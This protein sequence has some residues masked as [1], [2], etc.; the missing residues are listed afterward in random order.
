MELIAVKGVNP[1][2]SRRPEERARFRR[3]ISLL[4]WAKD[5]TG[6]P[7]G[8]VVRILLA[9]GKDDIDWPSAKNTDRAK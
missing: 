8:E 5:K 9:K 3:L 4:V 7:S 6:R 1:V 2:A